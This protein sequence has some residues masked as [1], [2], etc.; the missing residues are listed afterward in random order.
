MQECSSKAVTVI[1]KAGDEGVRSELVEAL[2]STLGGAG[3]AGAGAKAVQDQEKDADRELLLEVKGTEQVNKLK[4][5]KDLCRIA[6]EI[7]QRDMVYQF[8]EVHRHLSHYQDVKNAASGLA[9]I[10]SLDPKLKERLLVIAPKILLLTYDYNQGVRD[11]M[12]QLWC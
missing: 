3:E 5:F 4:T 11:T 12:K 9:G 6:N 7:G 2:S 10:M 8:M 1:Y